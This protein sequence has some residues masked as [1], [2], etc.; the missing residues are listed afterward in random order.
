MKSIVILSP[1]SVKAE[2]AHMNYHHIIKIRKLSK[3]E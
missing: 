2:T 3:T 1:V